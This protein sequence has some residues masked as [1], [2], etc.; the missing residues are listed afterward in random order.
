M[1][2]GERMADMIEDG[3]DLTIRTVLF[4]FHEP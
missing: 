1:N 3:H 4:K 2:I